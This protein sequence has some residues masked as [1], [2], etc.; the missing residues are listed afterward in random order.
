MFYHADRIIVNEPMK[1]TYE[2][3]EKKKREKKCRKG[4]KGEN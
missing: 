4:E 2:S 3:R 1:K